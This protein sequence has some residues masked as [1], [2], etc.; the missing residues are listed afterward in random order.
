MNIKRLN[1][2]IDLLRDRSK[3]PKGFTWNYGMT[4]NCAIGLAHDSFHVPCYSTALIDW[5]GADR[6]EAEKLFDIFLA[7]SASPR[8]KSGRVTSQRVANLLEELTN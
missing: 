3:W 2:L 7:A 4:C 1:R 8:S 6:Q 5:L